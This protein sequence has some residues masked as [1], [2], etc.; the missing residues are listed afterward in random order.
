MQFLA[1][2]IEAGIGGHEPM[3]EVLAR[4]HYREYELH[5]LRDT[6]RGRAVRS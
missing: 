2:R 5:D 1:E 3:L 6:D 4:R